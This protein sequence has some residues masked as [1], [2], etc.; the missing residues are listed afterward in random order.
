MIRLGGLDRASCTALTG[1]VNAAEKAA[2]MSGECDDYGGQKFQ[3]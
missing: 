1:N 2:D 3:R